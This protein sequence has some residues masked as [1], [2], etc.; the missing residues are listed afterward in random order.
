[1]TEVVPP[2]FLAVFGKTVPEAQCNTGLN[3]SSSSRGGIRAMGCQGKLFSN[4]VL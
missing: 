4:L 3:F 1:M 2:K